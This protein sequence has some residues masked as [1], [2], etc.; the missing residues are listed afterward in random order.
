M[1]RIIFKS[2]SYTLSFIFL[3]I[4]FV[5]SRYVVL[6]VDCHALRHVIDLVDTNKPIRELKHIIS[7]TDDDELGVFRSLFN[8]AGNNRHLMNVR[9][10]LR[11]LTRHYLRF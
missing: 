2:Y 5:S 9:T 10:N 4:T 3:D 7:Q 8:V 11:K 6:V 1:L